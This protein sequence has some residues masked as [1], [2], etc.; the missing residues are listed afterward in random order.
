MAFLERE[1]GYSELKAFIFLRK[2][3]IFRNFKK[4]IYFNMSRNSIRSFGFKT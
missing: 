2:F 1:N 4:K 3:V